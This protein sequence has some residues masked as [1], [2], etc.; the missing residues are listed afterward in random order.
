M[1]NGA[2]SIL[3]IIVFLMYAVGIVLFLINLFND[4]T[5]DAYFLRM[6][7]FCVL[8]VGAT[9]LGGLSGVFSNNNN[10]DS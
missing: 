6:K 8:M 5:N 4:S 3:A 10:S 7:I 2:K 9:L 1:S